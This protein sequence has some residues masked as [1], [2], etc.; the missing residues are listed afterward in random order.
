MAR[1]KVLAEAGLSQLADDDFS[2]T[3]LR[4]ATA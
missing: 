4:N 1:A 3:H 2:P